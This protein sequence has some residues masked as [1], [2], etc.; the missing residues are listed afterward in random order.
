MRRFAVFMWQQ[1]SEELREFQQALAPYC[2]TSTHG[3]GSRT[4][5][6]KEAVLGPEFTGSNYCFGRLLPSAQTTMEPLNPRAA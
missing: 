6:G 4:G 1:D 5:F 3:P 2:P